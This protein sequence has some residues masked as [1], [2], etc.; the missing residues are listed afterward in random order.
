MRAESS[1]AAI[2]NAQHSTYTTLSKDAMLFSTM[3]HYLACG[4]WMLCTLQRLGQATRSDL[5]QRMSDVSRF[6]EILPSSSQ[7]SLMSATDVIRF[8]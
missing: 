3:V 8:Y 6:S 5:A 1:L 4:A 7:D 2:C